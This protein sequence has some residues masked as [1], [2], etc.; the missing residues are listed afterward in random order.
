MSART[1]LTGLN[2]LDDAPTMIVTG[3][4]GTINT[5]CLF[6]AFLPPVWYAAQIRR[7]APKP[8]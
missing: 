6:L 2:V 8:A 5:A 4:L 7:R 1:A 3:V